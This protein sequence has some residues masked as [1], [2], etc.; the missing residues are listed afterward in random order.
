[1]S[2]GGKGPYTVILTAPTALKIAG[3]ITWIHYTNARP[4]D[5]EVEDP[6]E[7]SQKKKGPPGWRVECQDNHLRLKL[8]R[9]P[10]P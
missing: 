4:T 6:T 1:M 3:I 8:S 10:P 5:P 2:H 7:S 9:H